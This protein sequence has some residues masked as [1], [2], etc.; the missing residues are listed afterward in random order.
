M[1][2]EFI[3]IGIVGAT[4]RSMDGSIDDRIQT[5]AVDA[6]VVLRRCDEEHALGGGTHAEETY[7][8]VVGLD[9]DEVPVHIRVG[10]RT[11]AQLP[12]VS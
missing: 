7:H 10:I 12:K 11:V 5:R 1:N 2:K 3:F 6:L 4:D 8:N 9:R